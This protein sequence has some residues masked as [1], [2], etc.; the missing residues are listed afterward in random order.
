MNRFFRWGILIA[1]LVLVGSGFMAV[2]I[3]FSENKSVTMPSLVGIPVEEV[4]GKLEALGLSARID[5][6][7]SEQPSGIVVSQALDPGER[8]AKGKIVNIKVSKGGFQTQVPDVRGLSFAEAAKTLDLSGF[9]VGNVLRVTD[10]LKPAGTVIAQNPAAPAMVSGNRM[11][12][13]LISEG[14][15]GRKEMVLVPDLRGQTEKLAREIVQQSNL[16]VSSVITVESNVVPEG[17]IVRTQPRA[18]SRVPF[19]GAVSLYVA[20][21]GEDTTSNVAEPPYEPTKTVEAI[22]PSEPI[23]A[24]EEPPRPP[25]K[26]VV[27]TVPVVPPPAPQQTEPVPVPEQPVGKRTAKIRYQVP[28]L[29][30]SLLLKI[31]ITDQNGSRVLKEQQAK[32]GEYITIDAPYSGNAGVTVSLGGELVWQERYR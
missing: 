25:E 26:P 27:Q 29:S 22:P 28:P 10:P 21:A 18:G 17:N 9:K 19:G 31:E 20:R 30:K 13:L 7:E 2:R 32:G 23:K 5:W 15:E 3:I 14:G 8:L 4:G 11:V 1:L 16:T 6:I 24:A 12:G